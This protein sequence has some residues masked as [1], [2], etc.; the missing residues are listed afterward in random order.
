MTCGHCCY[1]CG[2]KGNDMTRVTFIKA[3]K[4]AEE[5]DG[6]IFLGGGE[7]TLHPKFWDFLGIAL[8]CAS[9]DGGGV[10]VI[11]NGKRAQDAIKLARLAKQ[12][13]IYAAVSHDDYHEEINLDVI[14]AFTKTKKYDDYNLNYD[15]DNRDIR[16]GGSILAAG[17]AKD[18]GVK[19]CCCS[20]IVID[21]LGNLFAC[22]CKTKSLGTLDKPEIPIDF[23]HGECYS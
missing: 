15:H 10:G 16:T 8:S 20:E 2:P 6:G 4:L 12:G 11:T 18:F 7:P 9:E 23:Q 14:K 3:C 21:P 1:N 22:G 13:A 17:R 19:G 5:Y